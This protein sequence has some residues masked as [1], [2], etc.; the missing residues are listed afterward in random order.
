[1]I[2]AGKPSA[3]AKKHFRQHNTA[4]PG[5]NMDLFYDRL[6]DPREKDLYRQI[7]T[8]V[9]RHLPSLSAGAGVPVRRLQTICRYVALDH[10]EFFW[11]AGDFSLSGNSGGPQTLSFRTRKP[12]HGPY[13]I[14]SLTASDMT[15]QPQIRQRRTARPFIPCS[16]GKKACASGLPGPSS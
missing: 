15:C 7:D 4:R 16:S 6:P 5:G 8:A 14:G 2:T 11:F 12:G 13:T 3:E 1:M 9:G 10:P